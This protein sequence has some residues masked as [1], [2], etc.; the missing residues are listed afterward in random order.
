MATKTITQLKKD[1][2]QLGQILIE[3]EK[4]HFDAKTG[5][6]HS[7]PKT[8]FFAPKSWADWKDTASRLGWSINVIHYA[9]KGVDCSFTNPDGTG[10]TK[11]GKVIETKQA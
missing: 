7:N 1:A 9:P 8:D 2:E 5:I 4:K 10:F 6:K 3:F 11:A